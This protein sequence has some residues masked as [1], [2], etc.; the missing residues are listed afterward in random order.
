MHSVE[1]MRE[2][3]RNRFSPAQN[4]HFHGGCQDITGET[5]ALIQWGELLAGASMFLGSIWE[6]SLLLRGALK[7]G[8]R[9]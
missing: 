3:R 5:V 8:G 4:L 7:S 9:L 1:E 2:E 6:D